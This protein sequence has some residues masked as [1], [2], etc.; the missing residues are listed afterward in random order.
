MFVVVGEPQ[1]DGVEFAGLFAQFHHV[2]DERRKYAAT[3]LEGFGERVALAQPAA[4]F[5]ERGTLPAGSALGFEI[6][7]AARVEAGAVGRTDA[8]EQVQQGAEAD[9]AARNGASFGWRR[10]RSWG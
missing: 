9:S 3:V 10:K 2:G 1:E 7:D 4:D 6:P 5:G 8:T